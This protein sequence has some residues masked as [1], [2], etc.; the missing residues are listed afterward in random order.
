MCKHLFQRY[1]V[2]QYFV[3]CYLAIECP[4]AC[5]K[6][7]ASFRA[8]CES[9]SRAKCGDDNIFRTM[10]DLAFALPL[11]T[12]LFD[13]TSQVLNSLGAKSSL[14][15]TRIKNHWFCSHWCAKQAE[16]I[17]Y[18]SSSWKHRVW[19]KIKAKIQDAITLF[20]NILHECNVTVLI[21]SVNS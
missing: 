1:T 9:A 17:S 18:L 13:M 15:S 10:T 5:Q 2:A 7:L 12:E 20:G 3:L 14:C 19:K 11:C 16:Y 6:C 4:R 8:F 21:F